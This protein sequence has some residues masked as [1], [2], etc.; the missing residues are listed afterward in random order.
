MLFSILTTIS[1]FERVEQ[2]LR[3]YGIWGLINH[4]V[5]SPFMAYSLISLLIFIRVGQTISRLATASHILWSFARDCGIP[6]WQHVSRVG[7]K[8]RLPL[9][10]IALTTTFTFVLNL[11]DLGLPFALNDIISLA[12]FSVFSMHLLV[13]SLLLWRRCDGSI[14]APSS[15]VGNTLNAPGKLIWGPHYIRGHLGAVANLIACAYLVVI[16]LFSVWPL[17]YQPTARKM[18]YAVFILTGVA[19]VAG[20]Y[21]LVWARKIFGGLS[22][23]T[24]EVSKESLG[25]AHRWHITKHEIKAF[26]VGVSRAFRKLYP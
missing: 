15:N 10:A 14:S 2:D 16:V 11:L 21:Y 25:W 12:V 23:R 4:A 18:N 22:L 8:R 5:R 24:S 20:F 7:T 17:A 26:W 1:S 9:V 13:L 6:G 19:I 3:R